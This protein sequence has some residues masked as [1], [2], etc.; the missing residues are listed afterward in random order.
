MNVGDEVIDLPPTFS[1]YSLSTILNRGVVKTINRNANFSIDDEKIYRSISK[2][3]K[4]IFICNPNNPTGTA[5]SLAVIEKI[6]QTGVIVCVDEA[7]IEFGGDTAIP[8]LNKYP[9]LII[10]R[11]FSKW[12]GIAGL[13]LGYGLMNEFLV[14]QLMKIKSPYNVNSAA[15]IGA[16]AS[17][18]D[19]RYREK[20]T[21]K[22]IEE[23]N[24]LEKEIRKFSKYMVY[25]SSGNFL[26]IQ[27]TKKQL[28]DI[29]MECKKTNISLRFYDIKEKGA[30]RITIRK[31]EQNKKIVTILKKCI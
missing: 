27:T 9:N 25:P 11:S 14:R 31:P 23:R 7:Y 10:I 13:R 18:Q 3:T 15:V 21:Q 6:L 30:V 5:T 29:K 19:V 8:L 2:K 22:I 12:A 28:E 17:L 20:I 1:S 24:K 4:I 26:Y 16:I